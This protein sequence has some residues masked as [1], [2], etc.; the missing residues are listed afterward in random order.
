VLF[1]IAL[2]M[3][4]AFLAFDESIFQKPQIFPA[5]YSYSFNELFCKVPNGKSLEEVHQLHNLEEY[6]SYFEMPENVPH[7]TVCYP[8][9]SNF[10]T[11]D[12]I[13]AAYDE[14]RNRVLYGYQLKEIDLRIKYI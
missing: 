9:H 12:V 11:Y 1:V 7:I 13:V 2:L 5:Q 14:N 6:I 10:Q 4:V 3:R 8:Q